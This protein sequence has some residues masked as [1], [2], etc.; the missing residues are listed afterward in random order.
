MFI[1]LL[2]RNSIT[3]TRHINECNIVLTSLLVVMLRVYLFFRRVDRLDCF[4]NSSPQ[5]PKNVI[6]T[7]AK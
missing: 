6:K 7:S 4:L 2:T 1:K 3:K 5:E